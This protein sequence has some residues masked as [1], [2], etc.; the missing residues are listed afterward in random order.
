M[1]ITYT[2]DPALKVIIDRADPR[3]R[4]WFTYG[5][6]DEQG[7]PFETADMPMDDQQAAAKVIDYVESM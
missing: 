7:T 6:G 3:A 1:T 4:V 5:D 2:A